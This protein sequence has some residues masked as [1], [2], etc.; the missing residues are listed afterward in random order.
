MILHL[1]SQTASKHWINIDFP[2]ESSLWLI[3]KFQCKINV[4]SPL[5]YQSHWFRVDWE[6]TVVEKP[7]TYSWL[8]NMVE[9]ASIY[10]WPGNMI[11]NA[12]IYGWPGNT[13]EKALIYSP[14]WPGNMIENTSRY[15][16]PGKMIENPSI[17]GWPG[18]HRVVDQRTSPDTSHFWTLDP[19]D[20]VNLLM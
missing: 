5:P 8:G 15:S 18:D 20:Q 11:E 10:S 13:I 6:T 7:S 3:L 19:Y 12:S 9:N 14:S 2:S 17:F 16:W 1:T 4:E